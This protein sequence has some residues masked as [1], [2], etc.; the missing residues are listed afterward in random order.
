[1][2]I[3]SVG[4]LLLRSIGDKGKKIIVKYGNW[5]MLMHSLFKSYASL[6]FSHLQKKKKNIGA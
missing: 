2:Y 6:M 4:G 5:I 3:L 1:M